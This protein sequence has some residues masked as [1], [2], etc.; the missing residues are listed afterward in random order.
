MN[1][2]EK[3]LQLLT[4]FHYVV[5]GV[6][7]LFACFPCIHLGLGIAMVSGEFPDNRGQPGPPPEIFGWLFIVIGS[8]GIIAGWAM[9]I[10]ILL[11]GRCLARRT[12]YMFCLVVAGIECL[13]M[14][15]GTVLG[16]FTIIVL[17][18]P[19]VKLLFQAGPAS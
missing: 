4:I 3:H 13:F 5:G 17:C 15:F 14:P 2:D 6:T 9:A 11:A 19:S 16:V 8:V 12:R 7:A 18:R 1:D 10:S